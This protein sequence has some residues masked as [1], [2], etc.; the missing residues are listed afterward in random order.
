MASAYA[1]RFFHKLLDYIDGVTYKIILMNTGFTFDP[2]AHHNYADVSANEL[3][4]GNGYTQNTKELA[5]PVLTEDD[6]NNRA[7]LVFDDAT[8][9][10]SGG[11][12]GPTAGAIIFMESETDDPIVKWI[13]PASE[14]TSVDGAPLIINGIGITLQGA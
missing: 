12:I 5:N 13:E 2:D 8:W 3:A 4:T 9:T 10:A 6:T 1:N 11:P 14:L 7:T